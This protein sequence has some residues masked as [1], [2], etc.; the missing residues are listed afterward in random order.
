M[1]ELWHNILINYGNWSTSIK[2][3][4]MMTYYFYVVG[5]ETVDITS[6][7]CE[8]LD[9][10]RDFYKDGPAAFWIRWRESQSSHN[11]IDRC[12]YVSLGPYGTPHNRVI[13]RL[14]DFPSLALWPEYEK[15][16]NDVPRRSNF[17]QYLPTRSQIDTSTI[18]SINGSLCWLRF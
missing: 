11:F 6:Q 1:H 13:Y 12:E 16:G 18:T 10:Q 4:M 14:L 3:R 9:L 8:I 17:A 2:K 15:R 5:Y 7:S